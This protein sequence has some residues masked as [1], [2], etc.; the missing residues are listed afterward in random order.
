MVGLELGADD[1][2]TKPFSPR[3][4]VLRVD[5]VLRRV[6]QR[7]R[8]RARTVTDGDLVVDPAEHSRHPRR[9]AARADR[10]RV[11]PAALP[12]RRTPARLSSATR[13]C[14]EVWGWS[15]GDQ[16]T[17]TVHVRR[18]REKVETD[19]TPPDPTRHRVGSRLPVG[20][21]RDRRPAHR[22]AHRRGLVRGV[23]RHRRPRRLADPTRLG[24][25]VCR[26]DRRRGRRRC[27][28]RCRRHRP[29]DVPVHARPSRRRD[30]GRGVSGLVSCGVRA[31]ARSHAGRRCAR[32]RLREHGAQP[33]GAARRCRPG[34]G[35]D[36]SSRGRRRR[37]GTQPATDSQRLPSPRTSA[38]A[39]PARARRVGLPRPAHAPGRAARHGRG[40]RRTASPTD[41]QRYHRQMLAEADRMATMVDDLFE[42]SRIHAGALNLAAPAG[43]VAA[44]WSASRSPGRGCRSARRVASTRRPSVRALRGHAPTRPRLSRV[45]GNLV[46]NAIRHT[47]ADGVV[48]VEGRTVTARWSSSR[49]PTAA[50]ASRET[51]L[52]RVFDVGLAREPDARTPEPYAGAGLGLAIV[53]GLV[54]AHPGNGHG[55]EPPGR[56]PVRGETACLVRA[57][58]PTR[59]SGQRMLTRGPS[60]R[61]CS[62][63][64]PRPTR[65]RAAGC[66]AAGTPRRR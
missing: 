34:P 7:H 61:R 25:L 54:E 55:G 19:P 47:P 31:P 43:G 24:P 26:A 65:A 45:V 14:S 4:L 29:G 59:A 40:A 18:L 64:L 15:F 2:V 30:R 48:L 49:S 3:E 66:G 11:R 17:V 62:S 1:Y 52:D 10:A 28:R 13:C 58:I 27:G 5:S 38:G 6:G 16:S 20:A 37:A 23:G 56:L 36:G 22:R 57:G 39:V 46:M 9:R 33:S 35:A 44:T 12:P 51:D 32:P 60:A 42:L 63:W 8:P 21:P 50:A 53:R 41:P